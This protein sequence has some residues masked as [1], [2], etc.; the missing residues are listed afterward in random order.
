MK[1]FLT[2]V[3]PLLA[4]LVIYIAYMT[5]V[6]GRRVRVADGAA[7]PAWWTTAPWARLVIAGVGCAAAVAVTLAMTGGQDPRD[8]YRPAR[9]ENGEI[10]RGQP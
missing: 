2:V 10:V 1:V 9:L 3:L 6:E 5:L 4:P 7:L 8:G